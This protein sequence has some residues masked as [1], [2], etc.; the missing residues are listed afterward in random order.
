[1]PLWD[2]FIGGWDKTRASNF[3]SA[4]SI[5]VFLESSQ[6][7]NNAKGKFLIGTPGL[8]TLCAL[9]PQTCRG[10]FSQNGRTFAVI[11]ARFLEINTIT[12]AA[13]DYGSVGNG[14]TPVSVASNGIGGNQLAIVS[15]GLLYIFD[16]ATNHLTPPV[17]TP[18][19][20]PL[21]I[22]IYIDGYFLALET[23]QV[24]VWFS[25][26]ENGNSWDALDFFARSDASDNLV[27]MVALK[28]RVWLFGSLTSEVFYNTGD[29]NNPFQP[30]PG[31]LIQE[32]ATSAYA[33]TVVGESVTWLSQDNQGTR[34][35]VAAINYD[36]QEISTPSICAALQACDTL[37]DAEVLAYEQE[38]HQF[39][40]WTI[41]NGQLTLG[42]DFTESDWHQ[43]ADIDVATGLDIQWRARGCAATPQGVLVGDFETGEL[44]FLD[45]E[46]YTN[47][48]RMLRRR[49]RAPYLSSDNQWM[50]LDQIELGLEAGVGLASGQGSDPVVELTLSRDG[51]KTWESAGE[52]SVGPMGE[53]D[54]RCLWAALGRVRADRLVIETVMTDPVKCY[55]GPGLWIR[56]SAGSGQL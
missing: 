9:T 37:E 42:F 22:V 15:N 21:S 7:K 18:N 19:T 31:S 1:M 25:A 36:P 10:I 51:G 6:D 32:G 54:T 12:G 28:N 46:T 39:V 56:A 47:G 5:N 14:S 3:N 43:R 11:G 24:R 48:G 50:F 2:G 13:V 45:M 17:T 8:A 23:N 4:K 49:R 20:N 16:L 33:I 52:G 41:P 35:I 44:Y 29:A 53:Y 26:L 30:Y 38:G 34:R 55:W 27:G 40:L